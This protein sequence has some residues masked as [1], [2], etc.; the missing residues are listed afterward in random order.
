MSLKSKEMCDVI[1]INMT[2]VSLPNLKDYL[3]NDV[4]LFTQQNTFFVIWTKVKQDVEIH[5]CKKK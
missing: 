5:S 4:R 3:H 1:S 2:E